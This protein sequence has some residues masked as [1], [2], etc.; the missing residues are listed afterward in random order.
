[1]YRLLKM[2]PV[3]CFENTQLFFGIP[4]VPR[5]L[6]FF[7]ENAQQPDENT[8]PKDHTK[9]LTWRKASSRD[10]EATRCCLIHGFCKTGKT[11]YTFSV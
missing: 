2:C 7:A 9:S 8:Q 10:A 1:M 5:G 11:I 6:D 3:N 4:T